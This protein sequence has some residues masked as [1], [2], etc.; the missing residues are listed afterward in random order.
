M[1]CRPCEN[2]ITDLDVCC[3]VT[4]E[5]DAKLDVRREA[6]CTRPIEAAVVKECY[7]CTEGTAQGTLNCNCVSGDLKS[8]NNCDECDCEV[9]LTGSPC[10]DV[11]LKGCTAEVKT[12][13][14]SGSIKVEV[15]VPIKGA[16]TNISGCTN[17]NKSHI[18][19]TD[20]VCIPESAI[21]INC[22]GR[23]NCCTNLDFCYDFKNFTTTKLEKSCPDGK[24]SVKVE[25]KVDIYVSCP[26]GSI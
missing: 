7:N 17:N 24:K 11:N 2:P 8:N 20:T 26:S 12:A 9:F 23:N 3:F 4:L 21:C 19:C 10:P 1:D 18:C 15:A 6:K 13:N 22:G 16:G 5:K 25:G 14:L